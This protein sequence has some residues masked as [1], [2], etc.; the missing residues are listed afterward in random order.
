MYIF[1]AEMLDLIINES[2]S[3]EDICLA[4]YSTDVVDY[5]PLFEG[6]IC[7]NCKVW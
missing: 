5:H 6:S 1:F 3:K 2:K 7:I 4:C